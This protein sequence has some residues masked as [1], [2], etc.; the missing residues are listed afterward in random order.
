MEGGIKDG[1]LGDGVASGSAYYFRSSQEE[2]EFVLLMGKEFDQSGC[3]IELM[4]EHRGKEIACVYLG[5]K[6]G[7]G[8]SIV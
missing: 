6:K 8:A 2:W 1:G 7:I 4:D 3:Y 5:C